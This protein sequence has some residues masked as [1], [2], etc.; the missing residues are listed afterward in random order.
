LCLFFAKLISYTFLF[1]LPTF[2]KQ[3]GV[4]VTSEEAAYFSIL[5][6]VG[7]I[8]GG[9]LAGLAADFTGKSACT[10]AVMLISSIPTVSVYSYFGRICPLDGQVSVLYN[11][12]L[13]H[14]CSGK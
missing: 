1:W 7:G 11:L 3:M 6:D 4:N 12:F 5:F 9:I 2:I 10:C 8:L 14:E 13:R